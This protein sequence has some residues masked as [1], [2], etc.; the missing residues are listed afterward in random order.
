[1][2]LI[3][4]SLHKIWMDGLR[5]DNGKSKFPHPLKWEHKNMDFI[6]I[7]LGTHNINGP[8]LAVTDNKSQNLC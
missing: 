7:L 6:F 1:M 5:T 3:M 4:L 8:V 2:N